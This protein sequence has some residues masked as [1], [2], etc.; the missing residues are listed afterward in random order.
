MLLE[1]IVALDM[2]LFP[3]TDFFMLFAFDLRVCAFDMAFD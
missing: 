2:R 1:R 3:A